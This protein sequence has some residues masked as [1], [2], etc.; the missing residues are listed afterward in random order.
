MQ[1]DTTATFRHASEADIPLVQDL[2][3]RI[4]REYYPG[5]ITHAQIDYMLGKMYATEVIGEEIRNK[6][7]CY[8]IVQ[9]GREAVG[10]IAWRFDTTV[11]VVL[12]SKLY[13]LPGLHGRG[14]GRQ[15]LQHVREDAVQQGAKRIQLFV[16]KNNT[17]AIAAYER[18]GFV[19]ADPV[20]SDIGGGF[21]MD[22]YRMELLL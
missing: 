3:S 8:V 11:K 14:I 12:I 19:K 7:Y 13:L 21:V 2:S 9:Q 5:I 20:V 10:Y 15:M 1:S 16:N 18:F 17:K 4:W 6:G 22:D